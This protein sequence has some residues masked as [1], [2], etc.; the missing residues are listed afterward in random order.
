MES[1]AGELLVRAILSGESST[2]VPGR[3]QSKFLT[4]KLALSINAI[5]WNGMISFNFQLTPEQRIAIRG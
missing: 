3:R 4:L 5:L 2:D 1:L